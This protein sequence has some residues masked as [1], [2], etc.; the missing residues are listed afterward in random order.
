M[1]G[2][3]PLSIYNYKI[4][5]HYLANSMPSVYVEGNGPPSH[6]LLVLYTRMLVPVVVVL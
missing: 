3:P 4:S 2:L 6:D 1:N 5:A